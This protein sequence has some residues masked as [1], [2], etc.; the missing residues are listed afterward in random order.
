MVTG[1]MHFERDLSRPETM[2]WNIESDPWLASTGGSVT[3]YD[4]P[5]DF[6]RFHRSMA[7][8]VAVAAR[9]RQRVVP[10]RGPLIAPHW[11]ADRDFDL[12]WHVRRIGAP[13]EGTLRE[14][15]DWVSQFFQDPF[16]R[17]RALWQYVVVDGLNEGQGALVTK[18]HHVVTDGQGAVQ[19]A[20]AY[21]TLQRRA[22]QPP[23]VDLDAVIGSDPQQ[24]EGLPAEARG[25]AAGAL[26]WPM[27]L[28]RKIIDVA[29]HPDRVL[30]AR[31]EATD[32]LRTTADQLRPAGSP[33]WQHRSRHRRLETLTVPFEAAHRTA[34]AHGGTLNDF[35]MTGA[36]EAAHRYHRAKGVAPERFHV[37]FV[38]STRTDAPSG[39]N[40]FTP[41]P[42]EI[43]SGE[44]G[45]AERF[46]AIH[47]RLA[48]RRNEVHGAG[49]IETVASVANFLPTALVTSLIRNQASHIDFATSSLPGFRGNTY[50]A[51]ART[52][53]TYA[54]GPL[55]GTAFNLTMFSSNRSLDIGAHLDPAAVTDAD[56]LRACL[57]DA[58]RDLIALA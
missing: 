30:Q 40:K 6:P 25:L 19:L 24:P 45:L 7:H 17:S 46:A 4:R 2:M 16:D 28:T 23:E 49:P 56:L 20:A 41:V 38:V 29:T 42:V 15:L 12:D 35:F 5:L 58:Y 34:K 33:L 39:L 57:E 21:V 54:F 14:L 52:L 22:P 48:A 8:A 10:A 32:L 53:H 55:A 31:G 11:V 36:G 18:M 1:D 26:R 47:E 43:P 50:V 3:V 13:G 37:T 27:E 9:L 51:G 44:M